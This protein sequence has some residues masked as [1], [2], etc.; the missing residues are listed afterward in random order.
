MERMPSSPRPQNDNENFPGHDIEITK[1][2]KLNN[3]S[4]RT[5]GAEAF[6]V[7]QQRSDSRNPVST[8][9]SIEATAKHSNVVIGTSMISVA[10]LLTQHSAVVL[11]FSDIIQQKCPREGPQRDSC[12]P[13]DSKL[14]KDHLNDLTRAALK[15]FVRYHNHVFCGEGQ[16]NPRAKMPL[17]LLRALNKL[18]LSAPPKLLPLLH[19]DWSRS[20]LM[21]I[22]SSGPDD[23]ADTMHAALVAYFEELP[24]VDLVIM[25]N[26]EQCYLIC[27][28]LFTLLLV[29]YYKNIAEIMRVYYCIGL[30][31]LLALHQDLRCT[32]EEHEAFWEAHNIP[33]AA[34]LM[35]LLQ[36]IKV[37]YNCRCSYVCDGLKHDIDCANLIPSLSKSADAAH[38]SSIVSE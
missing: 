36:R 13:A 18:A 7:M 30:R 28:Y 32:K 27:L 35:S 4:M 5:G 6:P 21:A 17:L 29:L 16:I 23:S 22:A 14:M 38:S 24:Q 12:S 26:D 31:I 2:F 34:S 9:S 19:S 25:M 1:H 15:E 37:L 8:D 33:S 11:P 3:R 10:P 20:P